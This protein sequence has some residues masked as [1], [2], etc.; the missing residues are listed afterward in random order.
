MNIFNK[1][2]DF[3]KNYS[4]ETVTIFPTDIEFAKSDLDAVMASKD[5]LRLW[6]DSDWPADNFT[7]EDNREDLKDHVEDNE[8]HCAYGFMLYD[9]SKKTCYGSL[10]VNPLNLESFKNDKSEI[11]KFDA[12]IDCWIRTDI[13]E[14]LKIAIV[15]DLTT[16]LNSDWSIQWGFSARPTLPQYQNLFSKSG[17]KCSLTLVYKE[18]N[19][20]YLYSL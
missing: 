3:P 19:E 7:E 9:S 11:E 20:L 10:Y 4:G 12:R 5:E 16:W 13:E 17:L 8:E 1:K 2:F 6:S 15:K 18:N 14:S